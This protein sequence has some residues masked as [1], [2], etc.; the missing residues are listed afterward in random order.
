VLSNFAFRKFS[1]VFLIFLCNIG[2]NCTGKTSLLSKLRSP[3]DEEI[4]KGSGLEFAYVNVHDEER[5]EHARLNV[6][7]LD[8]DGYHKDLLNYV[9]NADCIRNIVVIIAVDISRPWTIMDSLDQWTRILREHLHKLKLSAKELNEIEENL[10][11]QF[12]EYKEP[13][14]NDEKRPGTHSSS[15]APSKDEEDV[16]LPLDETI[17]SNNLGLPII[18]VATKSDCMSTLEKEN[19]Y[20]NDHFDFIQKYIRKFCLRY[21]AALIYTSSK[22]ERNI[23]NLYKYLIHRIYN[24][25]L[26]VPPQVVEKDSVFIP[27]GWDNENKI[28]ILDEHIKSFDSSDSFE[29]QISKPF[30]RK[31]ANMDKDVVAEEEQAFLATLEANLSKAVPQSAGMQKPQQEHTRLRGQISPGQRVIEKRTGIPTKPKQAEGAKTASPGGQAEGVLANFFNSLLTKKT[32]GGAGKPMTASQGERAAA[33]SDAAAELE[34]LTKKA[35]GQTARQAS[36]SST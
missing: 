25:P 1:S 35:Q 23:S 15:T 27:M 19:N 6:W 34:R 20:R 33:R 21:G 30:L 11:N 9:V 32:V 13:D 14:E 5:D 17:L 16:L 10:V 3:G 26:R 18:V 31:P 36:G 24:F 29:T 22:E 8:G 12:R 4:K 7:I 2:D 28:A